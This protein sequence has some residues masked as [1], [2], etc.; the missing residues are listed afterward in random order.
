MVMWDIMLVELDISYKLRT[1]IKV[2]AL[3]DFLIECAWPDDPLTEEPK[4]PP[5]ELADLGPR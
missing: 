4:M 2:Q 5:V 3:V 1:S